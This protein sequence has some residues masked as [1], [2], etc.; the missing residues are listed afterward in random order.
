MQ[1]PPSFKAR[2]SEY[3]HSNSNSYWDSWR[4]LSGAWHPAFGGPFYFSSCSLVPLNMNPGGGS[5]LRQ[6]LCSWFIYLEVQGVCHLPG[7]TCKIKC[8]SQ[9]LLEPG[10]P[11]VYL[12][13]Y[14]TEVNILRIM[15]CV[16]LNILP[17]CREKETFRNALY[18]LPI[19]IHKAYI[20]LLLVGNS[21]SSTS[22]GNYFNCLYLKHSAVV[23][24]FCG[25]LIQWP[26]LIL[27]CPSK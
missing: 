26:Q 3:P 20:P 2:V 8:L 1:K 21:F 15:A 17:G 4:T 9:V 24:E 5:C 11:A 10:L 27:A 23:I 6:H 16:L 14:Q 13:G 12:G 25:M 18:S 19:Q 7:N 22:K